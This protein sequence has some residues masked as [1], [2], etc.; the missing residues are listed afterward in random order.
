MSWKGERSVTG[1]FVFGRLDQN[2]TE[3][4][5]IPRSCCIVFCR[6]RRVSFSKQ[7]SSSGFKGVSWSKASNKWLASIKSNNATVHLG[8]FTDE[9][10]AAAAYDMATLLLKGKQ[11]KGINFPLS[12]YLDDDGNIIVDH[13]IRERIEGKR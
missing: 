12:N 8:Y 11:A 9:A 1:I 3:G 4:R 10:E 7:R 6:S 13:S 5:L 2:G